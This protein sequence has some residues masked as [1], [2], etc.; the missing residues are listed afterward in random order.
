MK[1]ILLVCSAGLSS[2]LLVNKMRTAVGEK[3]L[4]IEI[5]ALSVAE[6]SS[7]IDDVDVVFLGPQ[8]KFQKP[9]LDSMIKGRV[10]VEVINMRDYGSMNG[11]AVLE[12]ALKLLGI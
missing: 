7:V 11:R 3:G 2:S 10:P 12:R 4:E 8:V 6:S 9:M 1:K 5:F